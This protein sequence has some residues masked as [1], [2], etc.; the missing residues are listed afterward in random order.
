[1]TERAARRDPR[2]CPTHPGALLREDVIPGTGRSKSE[3]AAMLGIPR[4]HLRDILAER[5][6]VSASVAVRLGRLFGDGADVWLR[7][8]AA[9]DVW[10]A[11][12]E[13]AS[14]LRRIPSLKPRAARGG[15]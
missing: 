15:C 9:R 3:I 10:H 14:E 1:M 7:M 12:K 8:Q 5:K 2:R 13:L 6:P 11:E 4:Q